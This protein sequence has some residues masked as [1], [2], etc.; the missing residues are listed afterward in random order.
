MIRAI[1]D[2]PAPPMPTKC[3]WP[4]RS[5]GSS[6]SG[7]PFRTFIAPVSSTM[8]A[9][10]SSASRGIS[11]EAAALIAASR[12]ASVASAGTCAVTHALVNAASSTSSAPPASTTGLAF[13]GC[14]PLPNGSGT[15]IAGTPTAAASVT[16]EAPARQTMRSAA[17]RA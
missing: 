14:S 16:L 1:A 5:A 9:S 17:A 8:R 6:S 10:F 12:S 15:K 11:A 2:S 7:T 3:T 13:S 4:S